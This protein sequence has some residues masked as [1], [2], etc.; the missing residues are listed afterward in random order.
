VVAEREAAAEVAAPMG[1]AAGTQAAAGTQEALD[2][3]TAGVGVGH[4]MGT[5]TTKDRHR[6]CPHP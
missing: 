6:R 5:I 1:E 3:G 4:T 2:T